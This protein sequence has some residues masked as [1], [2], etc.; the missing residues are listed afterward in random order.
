MGADP[1][2]QLPFHNANVQWYYAGAMM[3]RGAERIM[4]RQARVKSAKEM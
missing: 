1:K 4:K 2:G 3:R